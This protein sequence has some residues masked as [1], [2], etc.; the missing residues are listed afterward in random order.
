MFA[1]THALLAMRL[2][3]PE[4][5]ISEIEAKQFMH[6]AQNVLRHYS[7]TTTQKTLDWT[8]F[9]GCALGIYGTRAFA[10][11]QRLKSERG[12]APERRGEILRWPVTPKPR[13]EQR[14]AQDAKAEREAPQAAPPDYVPSAPFGEPDGGGF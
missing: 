2:D 14:G 13:P 4:L 1:G 6:S 5:M 3:C 7:V 9:V 10:V 12:P 8:A 11:S